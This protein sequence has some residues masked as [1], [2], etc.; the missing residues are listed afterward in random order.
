[1]LVTGAA[2]RIGAA[3][4]ARLADRWDLRPTDRAGT[5]VPTLDVTDLDACREA[6]AGVDAVVHL[7]ADPDPEA[8][9]EALLPPNV[10][11]AWTVAAA[12]TAAGVRR[13][14]LASSLQT[15]S[16]VPGHRQVRARDAPRPANLYGAT[17]AW[18]EAVG[19]WVA[20]SSPV[21]VVA[22]RIGYYGEHPPREG[23]VP[24]VERAAWLSPDDCARLV[25]AAVEGPVHGFTVV[26]G[27][28]ANRYRRGEHGAAERDLGYEPRDDAWATN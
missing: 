9:W 15:M 2:G 5:G 23:E 14:V 10:V 11:G 6:F 26:D 12:A 19:S 28:S 7:A 20:S 27:V 24:A 21:E 3:T 17:K 22:L 1:M 8:T 13:L 18:A 4:T 16:A 25:V